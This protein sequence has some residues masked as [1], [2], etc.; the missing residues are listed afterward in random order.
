MTELEPL[1][2]SRRY[3]LPRITLKLLTT[4]LVACLGSF[5]FGYHMAELNAPQE[6]VMCHLPLDPSYRDTWFGRHGWKQCI[7][8]EESQYGLVTSIFSIGGLI[9][10][11]YA[12]PLADRYGRRNTSFGNCVLGGLGSLMLF[13]SNSYVELLAGRFIAGVASG[14]NIVVTPLLI[15]EVAPNAWKGALGSL[16]QVSI[17]LGILL[18]QLLAF[19]WANTLYWRW[20][21]FMAAA[22]AGINYGLLFMIEESPKW[23][24]ACG[25]EP[26]AAL[27]LARLRGVSHDQ[28]RLETNAWEQAREQE[29]S[30]STTGPS[31][32]EYVISKLYARPR[33]VIA[34]I[35]MGQQ[36]CGINAIIFYGV[37]VIGQALPDYAILVN[38][39]ISVLNVGVTC[40]AALVVDRCGRKPLLILSSGAMAAASLLIST[41]ILSHKP[42]LLVFSIFM[43]IAVF[44]LGM[45]PIPFLFISELS[46]LATVGVAQSFGITLNWLATFIVGFGFPILNQIIGGYV[47]VIFAAVAL[48]LSVY[49]WLCVPETN[50]KHTYQEIWAHPVRNN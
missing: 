14:S 3:P 18:T 35:L 12:G 1:L 41:G 8:L 7:H 29:V 2:A 4:T 11:L 9:G 15:N 24:M 25:H 28:A 13:F 10:S 19:F 20:L 32:L 5:Q 43:Y 17:N 34:V 6:A 44:A 33:T 30:G 36:L 40:A 47:F 45:G 31:L 50:G 37:H 39:I 27:V 23:L 26:Q 46:S 21:L 49:V 16:N 42:P 48:L 38:F 22:I